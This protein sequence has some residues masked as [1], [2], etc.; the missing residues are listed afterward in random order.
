[1]SLAD[2]A[3]DLHKAAAE[4]PER[5]AAV[6]EHAAVNLK[7]GWRENARRSAGKHGKHYPASIGYDE[8]RRNGGNVWTDV[9]PDS[10]MPQGGMSFE[11]G[12]R[13]QPP[14]LDGNRAADVEAPRFLKAMGDL[15]DGIL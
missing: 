8:L 5:T 2:L 15:A 13:N 11:Y 9:G 6:V 4:L 14:H 12:S 1:M 3:R 7:N 10:S